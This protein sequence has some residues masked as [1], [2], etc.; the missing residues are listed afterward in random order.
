[1]GGLPARTPCLLYGDARPQFRGDRRDVGAALE[2][3]VFEQKSDDGEEASEAGAHDEDPRERRAAGDGEGRPA[4]CLPRQRTYRASRNHDKVWRA[5]GGSSLRY[6]ARPCVTA[7]LLQ[8]VTLRPCGSRYA[9]GRDSCLPFGPRSK[10]AT[11]SSVRLSFWLPCFSFFSRFTYIDW[12]MALERGS[13]I[14]WSL[15]ILNP[16]TRS[17]VALT[18]CREP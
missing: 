1:M 13:R 14:T 5:P 9:L 10:W 3:V 16:S 8:G 11:R 6:P 17:R 15:R 4:R 7:A 18:D 2:P 12:S